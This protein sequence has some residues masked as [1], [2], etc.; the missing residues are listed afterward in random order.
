MAAG[1]GAV[2]EICDFILRAQGALDRVTEA[3]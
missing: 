3:A 2:R 1:R